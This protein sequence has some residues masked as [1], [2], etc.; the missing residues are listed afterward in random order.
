MCKKYNQGILIPLLLVF[1]LLFGS[2]AIAD[3]MDDVMV[4]VDA[5]AST[6]T[7]LADQAKLMTDDQDK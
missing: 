5:Y 6:E 3:D 1:P 2:S 4:V 7:N